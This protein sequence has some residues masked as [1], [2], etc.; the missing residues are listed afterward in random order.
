MHL[1]VAKQGLKFEK[2]SLA[3]VEDSLSFFLEK[4]VLEDICSKEDLGFIAADEDE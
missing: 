4:P 2:E 3:M 1:L